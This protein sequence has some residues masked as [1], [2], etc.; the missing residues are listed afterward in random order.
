MKRKL[1]CTIV[2]SVFFVFLIGVGVF[3]TRIF[4][5]VPK[6]L[7]YSPEQVSKILFENGTFG[8]RAEVTDPEDIREFLSLYDGITLKE[9]KTAIP[10]SEKD[11]SY[12]NVRLYNSDGNRLSSFQCG[13]NCITDY[14]GDRVY[15]MSK[16]IPWEIFEE[17]MQKYHISEK[18]RQEQGEQRK[19]VIEE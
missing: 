7:K 15:I 8:L 3:F 12:F 9:D 18:S 10:P 6:V 19:P 2:V 1:L 5:S 16:E 17:W 13:N 14:I 4:A 11:G